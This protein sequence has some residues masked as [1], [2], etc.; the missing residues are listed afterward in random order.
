[1]NID[2]GQPM[3]PSASFPSW[4]SLKARLQSL[5]RMSAIVFAFGLHRMFA[6]QFTPGPVSF[7]AITHAL[8]FC[9]RNVNSQRSEDYVSKIYWAFLTT[10]DPSNNELL[11]QHDEKERILLL[12]GSFQSVS[13]LLF[14]SMESMLFLCFPMIHL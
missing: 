7:L 4:V 1:M 9:K 5:L 3:F 6:S 10:T 14:S 2:K 11:R 8:F 12:Q 13:I